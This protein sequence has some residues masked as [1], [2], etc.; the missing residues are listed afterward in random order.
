MAMI[1][2]H[3]R[4]LA[5]DFAEQTIEDVVITVPAFFNQ[6]ERRAMVKAAEIAGLNLLQVT[7]ALCISDTYVYGPFDAKWHTFPDG[8]SGFFILCLLVAPDT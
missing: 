8:V 1:L 4:K 2:N 5:E 7:T 3:A 6:A